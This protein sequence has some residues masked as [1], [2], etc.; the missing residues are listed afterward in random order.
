[1]AKE[2]LV[3]RRTGVSPVLRLLVPA[4]SLRSAPPRLPPWIHRT[5]NA[6]LPLV[7]F[8]EDSSS[9]LE[10]WEEGR[11]Q[12]RRPLSVLGLLAPLGCLNPS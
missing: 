4:F 5:T 12:L 7:H 10:K 2:T 1:M 11:R 6:L 9:K 3:F 8:T